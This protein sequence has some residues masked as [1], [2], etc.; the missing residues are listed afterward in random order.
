MNGIRTQ[1]RTSRFALIGALATLAVVLLGLPAWTFG[2]PILLE[3]HARS[4]A[5]PGYP[6]ATLVKTTRS[7][8]A[9][10]ATEISDY[11]VAEDLKTIRHWMEVR[12]FQFAPCS[13]SVA[14]DCV[15]SDHCDDTVLVSLA[16]QSLQLGEQDLRA[17]VCASVVLEPDPEAEGY[18]FVHVNI[19]WPSS[20]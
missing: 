2:V 16:T 13:I 18:T 20:E 4:L 19:G 5:P 14:P 11:H 12:H 6:T 15:I 17:R 7:D 3:L 10:E 9:G 8:A 1:D